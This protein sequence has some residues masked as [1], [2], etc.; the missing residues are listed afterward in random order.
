MT[1]EIRFKGAV[2]FDTDESLQTA[3]QDAHTAI[4][5]ESNSLLEVSHVEPLG[6][7]V[8]V[9]HNTTGELAQITAS[10]Q[11]VHDLVAQAYSGYIDVTVNGEQERFH[12]KEI[13]PIEVDVEDI[14]D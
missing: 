13:D 14:T 8:T 3:L 4:E 2:T 9:T 5:A 7:H 1:Q 6:L 12:A 11:I 10:K